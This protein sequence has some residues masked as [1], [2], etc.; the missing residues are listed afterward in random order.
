MP[1]RKTATSPATH[2]A[3]VVATHVQGQHRTKPP[4]LPGHAPT[5]SRI[6][7]P[8]RYDYFKSSP[9]LP[10]PFA[11]CFRQGKGKDLL[12]AIPV[13]LASVLDSLPLAYTLKPCSVREIIS[14]CKSLEM[15][16][17]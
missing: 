3:T 10:T 11:L 14:S 4:P 16:Q 17:K 12:V 5:L 6:G 2:E 9:P 1:R 7:D 8:V 15:S 13:S